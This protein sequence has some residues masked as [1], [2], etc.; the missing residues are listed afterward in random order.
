MVVDG[1][2]TLSRGQLRWYEP[3]SLDVLLVS[4][5]QTPSPTCKG[6]NCPNMMRCLMCR[7]HIKQTLKLSNV[8]ER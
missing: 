2:L 1:L 5:S 4:R 8:I 3:G 7:L 6:N